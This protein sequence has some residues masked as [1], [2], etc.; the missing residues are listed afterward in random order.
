MISCGLDFGGLGGGSF[1][2]NKLDGFSLIADKRRT[3]YAFDQ[4]K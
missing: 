4:P 2:D 1:S 3:F